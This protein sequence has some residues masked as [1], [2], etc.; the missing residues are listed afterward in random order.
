[1][2]VLNDV[3]RD[4][5]VLR[6]AAS[7]AAASHDV[8]VIGTARPDEAGDGRERRDGFSV[9]RVAMLRRWPLWYV[10]LQHPWRLRRRLAG[11]I[12]AGARRG[13]RG[14]ARALLA[15]AA[16]NVTLPWIV[17]RGALHLASRELLRRP[18]GRNWLDYVLWWRSFVLGWGRAALAVVPPSDIHHANDMET[19]PTAI[20]AAHRDGGRVVYDSHEIFLEWGEHRRQPAW[21]RAVVGRWERRLAQRSAAVVTVNEAC[22]AE[23]ERRL[24]PRRI[25]VVHNCPPRWTPPEPPTNKLRLAAGIPGE[26]A[27]LLSHGAFQLNRGLEQTVAALAMPGLERSHLVLLGYRTEILEPILAASPDQARIHM[28]PAVPPDE[29]LGWV[30]GADVGLVVIQPTDLNKIVSSP[31]KLFESI[32]A[33]VPVVASDFP[34]MRGIVI[35]DPAGP[36]GAVCDPTDP[37]RIAAAIRSII[38]LD[39]A[40]RADLRLRCLDAA[41]ERWNWETESARLVELYASLATESASG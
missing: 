5:R 20:A 40:A 26:A 31:N 37:N 39:P 8:T 13:P 22:A 17:V 1:M 11:E 19:L 2:Y 38:E 33:G 3:T 24:H 9:I 12:R 25:V 41:H 32:A 14:A 6:E 34:V 36:L 35:D 16:A 7:L 27:I 4:S 10:W 28:L 30:T 23:L 29:L 15:I 21:L 18:S